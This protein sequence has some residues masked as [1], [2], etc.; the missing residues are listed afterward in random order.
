MF[1]SSAEEQATRTMKLTNASESKA[2]WKVRTTAPDSF[3]VAPRAGVL[4]AGECVE[5]AIT[6]LPGPVHGELR[7]EVR[8]VALDPARETFARNDWAEIPPSR[9]EVGYLRAARSLS[10]TL[11]PNADAA[12]LGAGLGAS[13]SWSG[14]NVDVDASYGPDDNYAQE[15]HRRPDV[16][17]S[18][19]EGRSRMCAREGE[20]LQRRSSAFRGS[21]ATGRDAYRPSSVVDSSAVASRAS[22]TA[23]L[24][25]AKR[26]S[27]K[28]PDNGSSDR[29]PPMG[30]VTK[31]VLGVLILILVFNLYLR[32]LLDA[33]LG[34]PA[35][36]T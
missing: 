29:P 28:S 19:L 30:P 1:P 12:R 7:F 22:S 14:S 26:P 27:S 16:D 6:L 23:S 21:F 24:S 33:A 20:T 17:G 35:G 9:Q 32:P 5:V 31:A 15:R 2:A 36:A 8:A 25:E 13:S 4:L 34:S 18:I 11:S 3:L 10:L